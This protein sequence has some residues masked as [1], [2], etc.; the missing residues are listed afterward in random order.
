MKK[1]SL[2]IGSEMMHPLPGRS[3]RTGRSMGGRKVR[4]AAAFPRTAGRAS[5]AP[6]KR[7]ALTAQRSRRS[8]LPCCTLRRAC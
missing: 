8:P 1:L 4:S 6:T 3:S 5:K 2:M 7:S